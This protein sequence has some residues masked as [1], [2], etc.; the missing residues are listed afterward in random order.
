MKAIIKEPEK[1]G[2]ALRVGESMA[3]I[4]AAIG[5]K[6]ENVKELHAGD[7]V[8]FFDEEKQ[9]LAYPRAFSCGFDIRTRFNDMNLWVRDVR[10]TVLVVGLLHGAY[11]DA[12][13]RLIRVAEDLA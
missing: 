7:T 13:A 1:F 9:T 5:A 8:F 11:T 10:G 3:E 2:R 6:P 4:A 12:P